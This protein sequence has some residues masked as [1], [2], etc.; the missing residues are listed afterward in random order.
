MIFT[1]NRLGWLLG[2]I[3]IGSGLVLAFA[4]HPLAFRCSYLSDRMEA[5]AALAGKKWAES[6][7]AQGTN[8][9]LEVRLGGNDMPTLSHEERDGVAVWTWN[10]EDAM[11]QAERMSISDAYNKKMLWLMKES[12]RAAGVTPGD[13]ER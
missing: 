2:G 4:I 8:R 1:Q 12:R 7:F 5:I 9:F 11:E 3:L 10:Y 13:H 6:D